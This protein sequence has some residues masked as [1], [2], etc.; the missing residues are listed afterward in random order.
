MNKIYL[1]N[2]TA[3]R[4]FPTAIEAML[5]FYKEKW[6]EEG[7]SDYEKAQ[8]QILECL[9]AQEGSGWHFCFSGAEAVHSAF[10]SHY[11][12]EVK[13]SGQNHILAPNTESAPI[14]LS[15][16]RMEEFACVGKRMAVNEQGQITKEILMRAVRPRTGLLSL[17]WAQG[18]TGVIQPVADLAE[19]CKEKNIALHVDASHVLGKLYFRLEDLPIDYFTFD[20][21]LIHAPEGTGGLITRKNLSFTSLV[22]GEK[23]A[24]MPLMAGLTQGLIESAKTC[25]HLC[26]ETARLRDKLE[27]GIRQKIPQAVVF[28]EQVERLPN[29]SAMGF[30]GVS[31]EALLYLLHQNGVYATIGGGAQQRLSHVLI[32]SGIDPLLA[33]SSLSFHLSF[34][35]TEREIDDAIETIYACFQRL[36]AYSMHIMEGIK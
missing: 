17:S 35:T 5:Y 34:E 23:T 8:Q 10:F 15:M 3:A 26:L 14:L 9:G 11:F 13:S 2:H 33:E 7:C 6:W 1:D 25:D 22:V 27:Y 36:N 16:Q 12:Q 30:P 4:P 29:C 32:A 24:P 19:V 20:G 18:L 28:F 31:G 21:K